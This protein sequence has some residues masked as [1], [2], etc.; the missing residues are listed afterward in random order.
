[1][2]HG[3]IASCAVGSQI[4]NLINEIMLNLNQTNSEKDVL[5]GCRIAVDPLSTESQV[6]LTIGVRPRRSLLAMKWWGVMGQSALAA[7]R[8]PRPSLSPRGLAMSLGETWKEQENR[9]AT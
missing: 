9:V 5:I 7:L 3:M 2:P 1:M 6:R 8:M 4:I